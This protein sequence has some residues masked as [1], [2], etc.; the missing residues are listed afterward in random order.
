MT[1]DQ[2]NEETEFI[3]IYMY[4]VKFLMQVIC[5]QL[6]GFCFYFPEQLFNFRRLEI[7]NWSWIPLYYEFI[8]CTI[9]RLKTI[10]IIRFKNNKHQEFNK[11]CLNENLLPI[12]TNIYMCIYSKYEILWLLIIAWCYYI[13]VIKKLWC[14]GYIRD[15]K[16]RLEEKH[17]L[18]FSSFDAMQYLKSF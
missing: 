18:C 8:H 6:L 10:N 7:E 16:T 17:L 15:I 11:I 13:Q 5:Y 14:I 1:A 9:F 12:Y 4:F 3:Y 2:E